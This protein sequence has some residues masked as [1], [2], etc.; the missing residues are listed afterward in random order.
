MSRDVHMVAK[1]RRIRSA[2]GHFAVL[3]CSCGY[4]TNAQPVA[5]VED[6]WDRHILLTIRANRATD[7]LP[8]LAYE[9]VLF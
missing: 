6:V 3:H 1:R 5:T 7:K 8:A 9:P 2:A 4:D